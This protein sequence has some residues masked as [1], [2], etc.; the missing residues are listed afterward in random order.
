MLSE[1]TPHHNRSQEADASPAEDIAKG[2]RSMKEA[3]RCLLKCEVCGR[4]AVHARA[5]SRLINTAFLSPPF[6]VKRKISLI[7]NRQS[8][9]PQLSGYEVSLIPDGSQDCQ[10]MLLLNMLK[11][12]ESV[13]G[14]AFCSVLG[15]N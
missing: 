4:R 2:N 3:F 11:M 15:L 5:I 9:C 8:S 13:Q 6:L 7:A 1:I 12:R 10:E 14:V